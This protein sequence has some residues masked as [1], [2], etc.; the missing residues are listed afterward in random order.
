MKQ[1]KEKWHCGPH[2]H[3]LTFLE[4]D[5]FCYGKDWFL[6]RKEPV[7]EYEECDYFIKLY[8]N[9]NCIKKDK[10]K[11]KKKAIQTPLT[12]FAKKDP[13]CYEKD[14]FF[15]FFFMKRI[16]FCTRIWG[17][18]LL[19]FI[20]FCLYIHRVHS[21]GSDQNCADAQVDL[22]F[23]WAPRKNFRTICISQSKLCLTRTFLLCMF[24]YLY[25]HYS[26]V[27]VF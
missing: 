23:H 14:C 21:E 3:P 16:C 17:L 8:I 5:C 7:F 12:L 19:L 9:V 2:P 18:W 22:S 20:Y 6:R 10:I 13:S 1:I 27:F 15:F 4:K 11:E 24:Y 25:V 26:F